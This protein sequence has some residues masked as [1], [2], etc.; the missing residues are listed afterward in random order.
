MAAVTHVADLPPDV[1]GLIDVHGDTLA[2]VDPRG[3]LGLPPQAP[4]PEQHLLL[5]HTPARFLLWVD[6]IEA[7][8]TVSSTMLEEVQ[9]DAEKASAL[10]IIRVDGQLVPV[11]SAAAFDPGPIVRAAHAAR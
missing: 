3:R 10:F 4:H 1:A 8:V 6:G 7:I 5:V 9:A 11:L 2:V